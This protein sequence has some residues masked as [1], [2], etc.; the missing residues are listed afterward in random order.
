M[1]KTIPNCNLFLYYD[2]LYTRVL[3]SL[4]QIIYFQWED[5]VSDIIVRRSGTIVIETTIQ[6]RKEV[7]VSN[8]RQP[9][10]I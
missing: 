8:Y 6:Q 5:N 4:K 1:N 2:S 3:S 9:Y 7:S 10:S